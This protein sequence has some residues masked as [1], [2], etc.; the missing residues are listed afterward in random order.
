MTINNPLGKTRVIVEVQGGLVANFA[1]SGPRKDDI[2]IETMDY[3]TESVDEDELEEDENGEQFF[4]GAE[5]GPVPD[6]LASDV[7]ITVRG[8]LVDEVDKPDDVIV[9][10]HDYDL[11]SYSGDENVEIVNDDYARIIH[12]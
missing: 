12:E 8:G 7:I 2:T 9:E 5:A 10:I 1:V 4:M 11:E 6:H 3:D